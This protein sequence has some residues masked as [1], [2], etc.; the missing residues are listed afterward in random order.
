[1]KQNEQCDYVVNYQLVYV[2]RGQLTGGQSKALVSDGELVLSKD[3]VLFNKVAT[4]KGPRMREYAHSISD[5]VY[6][7]LTG[8][9]GAF[10]TRIAY[11]VVKDKD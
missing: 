2:V 11:V 10:M 7:K 6:E 8:E 1:I 3:H 9:R 5:L 4:V